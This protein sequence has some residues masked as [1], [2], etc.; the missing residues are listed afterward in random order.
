MEKFDYLGTFV[1]S[2]DN[3]TLTFESTSFA[4]G[5]INKTTNGY[6]INYFITDHL[7]STR[8]TIDNAGEIKAQYNYYPFGKQWEDLNLMANTNRYTFSGKEKQTV[9]DLG[10]LDF[11]NR[12]YDS[13]IGRWFVIDRFAEKY[14]SLSPYSYGA[15]NPVNN[16]DINGDSIWITQ[17]T[18][19]LGLG[20]KQTLLYE[21]GNLYNKDGS[22]YTG[23]VKGFLNKTVNAL[24]TIGG[25]QE[26]KSMIN[27]LQSST[28]NFTII[29]GGESEFLANDTKKAYANQYQTDPSQVAALQTL[30]SRGINLSGGSGGTIRWNLSGAPLPTL[31]GLR[32]NATVDLSHEMFHAL[33]ANRGLLDSRTEQNVKRSEW[34]AVYRENI[35]RS[36]SGL[37]LR[38]HYRTGVNS[39]G[40]KIGIAPYMLDSSNRYI[41]PVWYK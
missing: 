39:S 36:Q 23:K 12:M 25:T 18:G 7:G 40:I 28:N 27:E 21:N 41:C 14:Y 19:F 8:V 10:Y 5:R 38:T 11:G 16:I 30:Q 34:Q 1:Y 24:N 32:T 2:R 17:R 26:G 4:G 35:L 9:K 31:M 6:D 3:D 22:E 29:K 15:L 33:D 20:K 13:E 37:P